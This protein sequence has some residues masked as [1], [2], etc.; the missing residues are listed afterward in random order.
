MLKHIENIGNIALCL[1]GDL[2]ATVAR[3]LA[4][5]QSRPKLTLA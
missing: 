1:D 5:A 4:L 2:L 3:P